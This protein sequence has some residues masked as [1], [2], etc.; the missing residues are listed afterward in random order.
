MSAAPSWGGKWGKGAFAGANVFGSGKANGG[1]WGGNAGWGGDVW[2]GASNKG[3]GKGKNKGKSWDAEWGGEEAEW[4][5]EQVSEE[6]VS[7][8][9][10]AYQM[11]K[12]M[13]RNSAAEDDSVFVRYEKGDAAKDDLEMLS[14]DAV[15]T[16][17]TIENSHIKRRPGTG[18]SEAVT[19]M[20]AF[21]NAVHS[22]TESFEQLRL[23]ELLDA[24]N[25]AG[26]WEIFEALNFVSKDDREVKPVTEHFEKL[27]NFME[28]HSDLIA[29]VVPKMAML[30]SRFYI[31][32][33][34]IL[35]LHAAFANLKT[36]AKEIPDKNSEAKAFQKW[37]EDPKNKSKALKA[38]AVLCV[39][40]KE[41]RENQSKKKGN[42]SRGLLTRGGHRLRRSGAATSLQALARKERKTRKR[43]GGARRV[44][45]LIV[46]K[47]CKTCFEK[48]GEEIRQEETH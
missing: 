39:E 44:L 5:D 33:N 37:K 12:K 19:S 23:A 29:E 14:P 28:K 41:Q 45:R 47:R 7:R 11:P 26:L 35:Q 21:M 43:K 24:A 32:G 13:L 3:K 1:K 42:D 4:G 38:I 16:R 6:K 30:G 10:A 34:H 25:E 31:G 9:Q 40:A 22:L 27:A 8:I 15:Y 18:F 36:L 20:K 17:M 2:W 48:E 46:K